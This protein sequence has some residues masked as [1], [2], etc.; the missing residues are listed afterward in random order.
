MNEVT[1]LVNKISTYILK[2]LIYLMFAV[3]T[4]VFIWGIRGYIGSADDAEARAKGAQQMIWGI[5][6][7]AI[8]IGAVALVEIIKNTATVL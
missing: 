7:M 1:I 3:A 2:P 5:V 4:L 8:M 6:G